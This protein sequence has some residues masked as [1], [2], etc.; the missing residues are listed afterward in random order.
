MHAKNKLR[1]DNDDL[2]NILDSVIYTYGNSLQDF[3]GE[4]CGSFLR[5]AN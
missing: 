3:D 4:M 1:V 5:Y 2:S